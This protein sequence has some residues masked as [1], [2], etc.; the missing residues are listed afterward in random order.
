METS[1]AATHFLRSTLALALCATIGLAACQGEGD[2]DNETDTM[3]ATT[4]DTSAG[5]AGAAD[6]TSA[7]GTMPPNT[8]ATMTDANIAAK[9]A[10]MDS[11]EIELGRLGVEKAKNADVKAYAQM[12]VDHHTAMKSEGAAAAQ[13][14]GVTPSLPPDDMTAQDLTTARDRL[15]ATDAASFDR[16]YMDQ[17]VA[18]HQKAISTLQ[19]LMPQAQGAALKEHMA[20]GLP[21]VQEHLDRAMQLQQKVS[22]TASR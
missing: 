8:T 15:M 9:L 17:M 22:V 3:P 6:T 2:A 19:T 11:A 18:D 13:K 16:A 12:M 20:K 4:G 7:P 21:K 14:D 1:M 5:P 10:M